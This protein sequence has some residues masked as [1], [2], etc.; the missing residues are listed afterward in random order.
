MVFP[1]IAKGFS[2]LPAN[3]QVQEIITIITI[4]IYHITIIMQVLRCV[5]TRN[6]VLIV[7]RNRIQAIFEVKPREQPKM[8]LRKLTTLLDIGSIST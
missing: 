5:M 1:L 4:A 6:R 8:F 7:W 3:L 2:F